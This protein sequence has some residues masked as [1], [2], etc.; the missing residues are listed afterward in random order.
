MKIH[1]NNARAFVA[2][3]ENLA[4]IAGIDN[5]EAEK[6]YYRLCRL[7]A[8][9]HRLA[10]WGCNTGEE[11]TSQDDKIEAK[12]QKLFNGKLNGFFINGDP[13]GYS[14]KIKEEARKEYEA[15]G[16]NLYSDWGGYGIL[17]PEF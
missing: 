10:E 12:I 6:L 14:L 11:T 15:K 8:K 7:E 1:S 13:R 4:K 3:I 9:A 16:I 17:A 2:H 5:W